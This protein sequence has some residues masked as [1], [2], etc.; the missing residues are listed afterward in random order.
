MVRFQISTLLLLALSSVSAQSTGSA[1]PTGWDCRPASRTYGSCGFKFQA[2]A[3]TE[4]SSLAPC[5]CYQDEVWAPDR[6]DSVRDSCVTAKLDA[7]RFR[8]TPYTNALTRIPEV[9][10]TKLC[11]SVGDIGGEE[12]SVKESR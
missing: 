3:R 8:T 5:L 6:F 10:K 9:T 12:K 7:D 1:R 4:F 2:E 11:R